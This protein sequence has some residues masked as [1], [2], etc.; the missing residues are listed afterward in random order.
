MV[1]DNKKMER[2]TEGAGHFGKENLIPDGAFSPESKY[3]LLLGMGNDSHS[4]ISLP[5]M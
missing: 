4:A 5:P 1:E 3:Y 2:S